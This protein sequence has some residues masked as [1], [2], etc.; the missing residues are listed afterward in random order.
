MKQKF[1]WD[2]IHPPKTHT[3]STIIPWKGVEKDWYVWTAN[4]GLI[5]LNCQ[6]TWK[7]KTSNSSC[8]K[9][10]KMTK[11]RQIVFWHEH[12]ITWRQ[13]K[14]GLLPS[15]SQIRTATVQEH[16]CKKI[17][18]QVH[19]NMLVHA[20]SHPTHPLQ[21]LP[22]A[23]SECRMTVASEVKKGVKGVSGIYYLVQLTQF[24]KEKLAHK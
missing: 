14:Q 9:K 1:V 18:F 11:R 16:L 5:C 4:Q 13:N 20:H 2:C 22:L 23:P 3:K 17:Y 6:S 21:Q 15:L 24:G 7:S 8:A 12:K 19:N 10:L